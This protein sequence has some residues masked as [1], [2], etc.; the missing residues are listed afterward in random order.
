MFL[1][2][3]TLSGWELVSQN[4]KE[5][6]G[7]LNQRDLSN[8]NNYYLIAQSTY[9]HKNVNFFI[10]LNTSKHIEVCWKSTVVI[11]QTARNSK[12]NDS[13]YYKNSS[14]N[15][16]FENSPYCNYTPIIPQL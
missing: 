2:G 14:Q 13:S 12:F 9:A 8:K 5:C 15:R 6:G 3:S 10:S 11:F 16:H 4:V 1:M 7:Y